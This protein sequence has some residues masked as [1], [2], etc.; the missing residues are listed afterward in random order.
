MPF[1]RGRYYMNPIAG[2]AIEAAR[3]AEAALA[4][5]EQS[6]H[7][8]IANNASSQSSANNAS[9]DDDGFDDASCA[10]SNA[11]RANAGPI[12]RVEIEAA[13]VMPS[14]SGR[15]Q[16]GYVAH[17]DRELSAGRLPA[18][19]SGGFGAGGIGAAAAQ[20]RMQPGD[21][22]SA[23]Y[24][25]RPETHVFSDHRDLVSFLRDEFA[26]DCRK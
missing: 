21:Y 15:A 10:T 9:G 18:R 22:P 16:R 2:E 7:D 3:A 14:H 20:Q 4:D 26:K 25:P 19:A 8:D 12:H 1:I 6:A 23:A 13:E 17:V 24:P 11:A 5:L